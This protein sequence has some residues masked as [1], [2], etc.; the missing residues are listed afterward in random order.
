MSSCPNVNSPEWEALVNDPK[1]GSFK[2]YKDFFESGTIRTPEEVKATMEQRENQP[3]TIRMQEESINELYQEYGL[4]NNVELNIDD[5]KQNRAQ[6]FAAK[7]SQA[8]NVDYE[9]LTP[10][11]AKEIT[12]DSNNPWTGQ[13]GFFFGGK[14]YFISD[15]L[16][17]DLV[18]HEFAHP[19]VRNIAKQNKKLFN[20]LYNEVANTREGQGIIDEVTRAY[21]YLT[22]ESDLFKEEVIV[23]AL[24]KSASKK[25]ANENTSPSFVQ[26]IKNILYSI[27]QALRK[28]FGRDIPVSKLSATT[29]LNDLSEILVKGANLTLDKELINEEDVVAYNQSAIDALTKDLE[30]LDKEDI[31]I[32]INRFYDTLGTQI[33]MLIK[34][35]N[36]DELARI[37]MSN[38]TNSNLQSMRSNLSAYQTT[39]IREAEKLR[40]EIIEGR[41]RVTALANTL[42][43]LDSVLNKMRAHT[44]D[45]EKNAETKDA[46]HKATYYKKIADYWAGFIQEFNEALDESEVPTSSPLVSLVS[47]I[48]RS[49]KKTQQSTDKMM[50]EGAIEGLWD[51]LSP[52]SK[53]ISERYERIIKDLEERG[54]PINRVNRVYREYH[55]MN[56]DQ[57]ERFQELSSLKKE[58]GKLPIKLEAE[59]A[60]LRALTKGGLSISREK[61]RALMK[62]EAGDANY[63]NS[64]LEGY[65]YNAD[66]IVGGLALYVKN[67]LNDVMIVTQKK[68]NTFAEEM[69]PLLIAAGYNPSKVGELGEKVGFLDTVG[70]YDEETDT[71]VER[72]IWTLIHRFK[73]YRLDEDRLEHEVKKTYEENVKNPNAANKA[74][75]IA[76]KAA[77]R[78]FKIDYMNQEYVPEYYERKERLQKSA[79]GIEALA[80]IED[81]FERL[82]EVTSPNA[83][84]IDK[85][86]SYDMI[87]ALW[88]EYRQAHSMYD[89]NGVLKSNEPVVDPATGRTSPSPLSVAKELRQY[90]KDGQKFFEYKLRTNA[91]ENAYD[92]YKQELIAEGITPTDPNYKERINLWLERNTR[93]VIKQE[94][95]EEKKRILAEIDVILKK[96]KDKELKDSLDQSQIWE[97]ILG[98][99]QTVRDNNNQIQGDELSE[100]SIATIKQLQEKLEEMKRNT[101]GKSGLTPNESSRLND[102]LEKQANNRPLTPGE[103][104]EMRDLF[105]KRNKYG[106]SRADS[107]NLT[108]LYKELGELTSKEST[109]YYTDIV[110]NWLSQLNTNTLFL[111]LGKRSITPQ[112]ADTLLSDTMINPL[113]EQ[114]AEFK[115][116]W[117]SNHIRVEKWD[118]SKMVNQWQR[119]YAWN[120]TKP[121][122]SNMMETYTI[123]DSVGNT[124]TIQ[125]LP[126]MDYYY[127]SVKTKYRTRKIVGETINNRGRWL[128]K[129]EAK[130]SKYINTD[131]TDMQK[132][133]P[134]LFAVLEKL[135]EHHL[136]NQTG[137]GNNSKLYY[138]FP[139][140]QKDTL[141]GLQGTT[142]EDAKKKGL[143]GLTWLSRRIKGFYRKEADDAQQGL[144]EN[145]KFNLVRTDMFDNDITS[146]PIA[147]LYNLDYNDVS[148]DITKSMM[149]YMLSAERQKQLVEISPFVRSVQSTLQSED[150]TIKDPNLVDRDNFMNRNIIRYMPK[151]EDKNIRLTAVNNLLSREFEGQNQTGLGK[152]VPWLHNLSNLL[153]KRA[154]FAFFALNIPSALKNSLGMKF[155]HMIQAAGGEYVDLPNLGKGK[156]WAYKVMGEYSGKMLYLKRGAQDLNHQIT[157]I[158][159]PVQDRF[160]DNFAERMSR[161][162]AADA[163]SGSWLYSIRKWV[164]I[165]AS[166]ELFAGMM[167]KQKLQQTINGET[168]TISYMDAWEVNEDKQ[169]VLK[170]GIDI[171]YSKEATIHELNENDTIESLAKMYNVPV[172]DL[173]D[174]LKGQDLQQ[175]LR[176]AKTEENNRQQE[177][178][179]L[180]SL[181]ADAD[182]LESQKY[183]D[184]VDAINKKYDAKIADTASV[185]IDN[186]LFKQFKNRQ[187]QVQNDMGGAY[188]K[189]DQP[190]AQRYIW[191]R[192]ISYMRRYFTTMAMK[193]WAFRGSVKDPRARLNPGLGGAQ[194]GYYIEATRALVD[195]VR[196]GGKEIQYMSPTEK[197]AIIKFGTEVGMLMLTMMA[198][199]LFGWDPDDEERIR[200][201]KEKSGALPFFGLTEDDPNRPFNLGGY[202]QVHALHLLMQVRAENEQFNL[203]TGGI[204]NYKE[205]LDL[206]SVAFGP[207]TDSYVTIWSDLKNE[208]TGSP[209]ADYTRRIGP[210]AWQ[211]KGGSKWLAHTMTAFGLTGSSLDAAK[212]V[213][214]FQGFQAKIRR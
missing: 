198:F 55:G 163:A 20:N 3:M 166:L 34:N 132:N 66:P 192:F 52:M 31:Q 171:R 2:A 18:F 213:E 61:I 30:Y 109:E 80:Y 143:T 142:L 173:Q 112:E 87:Q 203:F 69:R 176:K 19:I 150:N 167:Y 189:F 43:T 15:R 157:E 92:S 42:F 158:F 162:T 151:R 172:E 169:I 22:P 72:Q 14:V 98:M 16:T 170:P 146:V 93:T 191:F 194:M 46:M 102:I 211:Q 145:Q 95:Y 119:L 186:L 160:S 94:Y 104:S 179:N 105:E 53:D 103:I 144:N 113:L 147:G 115:K 136:K 135:K 60:K 48:E 128:P 54:A 28:I 107:A 84:E 125:G 178:T 86:D 76:A 5:I 138:D 17:T 38:Q 106:L 90:R 121:S 161:T 117:E 6:E 8:L 168:K 210:Y 101:M 139:R 214:G 185:K 21:D 206:K 83:T 199:G 25:L 33:N 126:S 99:T 26:A 37:L 77:Q 182:M 140:F 156:L 129:L 164:E 131:Y 202:M 7:L 207:T 200:K 175:K 184:R 41:T 120:V 155:Q 58:K 174:M 45:L 177:L 196:T 114:N 71:I 10:E 100:G 137:L 51:Q 148:T 205:L 74:A 154:S 212:A 197:S 65:L 187:Q 59:L 79:S 81:F 4:K 44:K 193:R 159:D 116:W 36:Y 23:K 96:L 130:D 201:L 208:L 35:K 9:M 64:Y 204:N 165:Q 91:F 195:I 29:T 183:Q 108:R 152:D 62:G 97:E 12:K 49:I 75:H 188:A 123:K 67:K 57:W 1:I 24:E 141:E 122:D 85:L 190:E 27:K 134:N 209:K 180:G 133:D 82:A 73:N 118:G 47:S 153:F 70:Q 149:R 32:T 88:R 68:F 50:E 111:E 181:S 78:Q 124:E 63:F 56:K 127:R 89:E 40:D 110:N 13:A 39:V 11:E